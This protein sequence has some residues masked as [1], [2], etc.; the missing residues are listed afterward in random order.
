MVRGNNVK[1]AFFV[2][3][4]VLWAGHA[5]AQQLLFDAAPTPTG[6]INNVCNGGVTVAVQT[7][8]PTTIGRIKQH[9]VAASATSVRFAI[10]SGSTHV[11]YSTPVAVAAGA[12]TVESPDFTFQLTIGIRYHIGAIVQG[13]ADFPTDTSPATVVAIQSFATN[14]LPT[15]FGAPVGPNQSGSSDPRVLLF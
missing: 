9:I 7:A 5:E 11:L 1:T 10:W 13:C 3:V 2:A 15:N 12:Q 4:C 6:S 8:R 14:G